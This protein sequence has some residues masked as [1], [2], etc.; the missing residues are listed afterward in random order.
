VIG[1]ET[2]EWRVPVRGMRSLVDS[3]LT[4]CR[5]HGVKLLS[6]A[7][8]TRV[9]PGRG[10][11]T[12]RFEHAGVELHAT[13]PHVLINA[14]PRTFARLLDT[15]WSPVPDD[16][17]SVIK[18]NVLLSRLPKIRARGI[19]PTEAFT[20]SLHLNEG[21]QQMLRS[22]QQASR[23]E[24]PDPAPCETYCHTLTDPSILSPELQVRGYHTLTLFGLD[25][26]HRLFTHDHDAR[27][28]TVRDRYLQALD[29]IC[30]ESFVDCLARDRDGQPCLE[31]KSPVDL[32]QEL[33]LDLGNIFHNAPSWFFTDDPDA[34]G[35]WGVETAWP[36]IVRAGSAA[37]RGGAV[38]G[39]PGRN[40]AMSILQPARS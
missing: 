33:G 16:E 8:A 21:Y 20:G 40:A 36:G 35:T 13:A 4:V 19:T 6:S 3:L 12:V 9:E 11:H 37:V 29:G 34:V 24:L 17:G 15:A 5:R 1:Q 23:G 26:P 32:E 27:L 10:L 22:W 18:M 28:A 14:G 38:S 2:G 7:S 39:I 30:D 31:I 25:M